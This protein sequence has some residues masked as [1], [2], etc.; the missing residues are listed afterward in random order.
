MKRLSFTIKRKLLITYLIVLLV[1]SFMIGILSYESAKNANAED[2]MNSALEST[3][4][5][6]NIVTQ[7]IQAK[8]DDI[9]YLLKQPYLERAIEDPMGKGAELKLQL[10]RYLEMN[11]DAKDIILGV[12]GGYFLRASEDPLPEQYDVTKQDWYIRALK[13]GKTPTISPVFKAAN[14]KMA[15]SI[16]QAAPSGKGVLSIEL[17]LDN[18]RTLTNMKLGNKGYIFITDQAKNYVVHPNYTGQKAEGDYLKPLYASA[19]GHFSYTFEN[20]NKRMAF[21]TNK[22]TG[23]KIAGSMYEDEIEA[24]AAGI[25]NSVMIVMIISILAALVII[26]LNIRSI[27]RPITKL[28]QATERISQGDLTENIDTSSRDEIGNLSRH[29]QVMVDNLRTMIVNV[30]DI[31]GQ[32]SMSAK[33]LSTGADQTTKAIESVTEAIQEVAVGSEQ[34]LRSV[35]KSMESMDVMSMQSESIRSHMDDA[36]AK[37]SRT[38]ASAEEGHAAVVDVTD[39]I[40]GIHTT[41]SDLDGVV[42]HMNERTSRIGEIVTMM[43]EIAKQTHL[44]ALNASIEAARAGEHGRGFAVVA[45]EVRKL[46]EQSG[47]SAQRI[48]ELVDG[49]RTEMQRVLTAMDDA[50]GRVS[51]GI[52][53]V[54]VTGKSFTRIRKAVEGAAVGIASAAEASRELARNGESAMESI[55]SIQSISEIAADNT[56]SVSASAQEQ[57]ASIEEIA[58]SAEHLSRLAEQLQELVSKFKIA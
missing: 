16:S 26:F 54:D 2:M 33:G 11:K 42:A 37:M 53:A 51:E 45:V 5:A 13:Q 30:Q 58:S 23:W 28:T 41:V 38:S 21:T 24:S 9:A 17:N 43:A 12:D 7:S 46:A 25:R 19:E 55:R 39:K 31:T 34:Q 8:I 27:I 57:L 48:E 15:V 56:Q 4:S 44:L 36:S 52:Q 22:L 14:G 6:D 35:E 32:V 1:P 40:Q 3:K 50:K 18:I 47:N 20:E 10:R 49:M 29:F